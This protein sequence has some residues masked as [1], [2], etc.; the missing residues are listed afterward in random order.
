MLASELIAWTQL[1]AFDNTPA[2][3]WEP[4]KLRLRLFSIAAKLSRHARQTRLKLA[5]AAP[6]KNLLLTGLAR[7]AALPDPG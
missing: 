7:L 5:A 1:L 3:R 2:R 6:H 4:K